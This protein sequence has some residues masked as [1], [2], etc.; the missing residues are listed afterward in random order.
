MIGSSRFDRAKAGPDEIEIGWTFL[1]RSH[2]GGRTN[3]A[4]KRLMLRH[5]L[6]YYQQVIFSVG[7]NNLRSRKALEKIG[8]SLTNRTVMVNLSGGPVRHVIYQMDR[9]SFAHGPLAGLSE[10]VRAQ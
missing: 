9:D 10:N 5:A 4:L 2:W 7:E 8:A 1:A 3:A 6:S